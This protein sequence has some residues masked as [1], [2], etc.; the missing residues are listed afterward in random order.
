MSLITF[1]KKKVTLRISSKELIKL[2]QHYGNYTDSNG[3]L[4]QT[5][6]KDCILNQAFWL[7]SKRKRTVEKTRA[8]VSNHPKSHETIVEFRLEY[9]AIDFIRE[10]YYADE[11]YNLIPCTST[12][13]RCCIADVCDDVS[14]HQELRLQDSMMYM[15]GQKNPTMLKFLEESFASVRTDH[16]IEGYVELFAGTANVLLHSENADVEYLNDNSN[17]LINLLRT[18]QQHPYLFKLALWQLGLSK[19]SFQ[20]AKEFFKNVKDN[21]KDNNLPTK[22]YRF[23]VEYYAY[24]FYM[25][26]LSFK[27][28]GHTFLD[29]KTIEAYRKH[30]DLINLLSER[31]TNVHIKKR[32][33]LYFGECL[34]K[35]LCIRNHIVYIDSPYIGTEDYY[36]MN[37]KNKSIFYDHSG[38]RNLV[39]KLRKNDN[40][41]FVSYRI[42][43]SETM[44]KKG[45]TSEVICRRLDSLYCNRGFYYRLQPLP[46]G[47]VEILLCTVEILGWTKYNK[48]LL[49][50][51]GVL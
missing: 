12:A 11:N 37:R 36:Q 24:F 20:F 50:K 27:G 48:P 25:R 19:E 2:R 7:K 5:C 35:K 23:K 15:M 46:K 38:L 6:V 41:A 33:A 14:T 40:Y 44:K 28:T 34:W 42:T 17:D 9:T 1:N 45:I 18:I 3:K 31:L 29:N 43:A 16:N 10:Y 26:Y 8:V 4:I 51:G 47:Q 13:I 22:S 30:L 21:N 39:E 32:D 49:E